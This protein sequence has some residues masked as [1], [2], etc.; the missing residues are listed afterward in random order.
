MQH[1]RPELNPTLSFRR[2]MY[3]PLVP[4]TQRVWPARAQSVRRII[5][6]NSQCGGQQNEVLQLIFILA[7]IHM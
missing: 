2:R 3:A 4:A 6:D 7:R 1:P 5:F